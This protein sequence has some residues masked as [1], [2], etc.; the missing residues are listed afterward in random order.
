MAEKNNVTVLLSG[1]IDSTACICFYLQRELPVR[2]IF[3]DYGQVSAA[4]ERHA[5]MVIGRHYG[6]SVHPIT[7]H[8]TKSWEGGC[9]LGRN[10]L[11]LYIALINMDASHGLIAMGIHAGTDYWDC[12]ADF[13]NVTQK[14]FDHYGDNRIRIDTPFLEWSKNEIW[15]YCLQAGVPVNRTYSCGNRS[16][17]LKKVERISQKRLARSETDD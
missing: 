11:L 3:V 13:V 10:A 6:V 17:F 16:Q 7:I 15:N 1:G 9:V 8:G 14:C 4:K 5:A 12:S 2:A